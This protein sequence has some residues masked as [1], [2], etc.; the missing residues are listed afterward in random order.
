MTE[1]EAIKELEKF[2]LQIEHSIAEEDCCEYGNSGKTLQEDK[3]FL[4]AFDVAITALKEVQQYREMNRKLREKYG[5]CDGLLEMAVEGLCKHSGVDIGSPKKSRLLTDED[6]DKW[7]AYK[8]IGTVE[9]C[10]EATRKQTREKVTADSEVIYNMEWKCLKCG[11]SLTDTDVL[12]GHC[13]WCGQA[14]YTPE[15][16]NGQ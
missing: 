8:A 2:Q 12:A 6:V 11:G 9:E 10:R 1:N 4:D 7:D 14:T 5:D 15:P 13:K 16:P 3:E